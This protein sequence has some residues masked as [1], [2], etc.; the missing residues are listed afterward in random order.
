MRDSNLK[1]KSP[2]GEYVVPLANNI[3]RPVDE[4]LAE[5]ECGAAPVHLDY[6]D[7]I[8]WRCDSICKKSVADVVDVVQEE[9][10]SER[11]EVD[12][13]HVEPRNR[14]RN[15]NICPTAYHCRSFQV[16]NDFLRFRHEALPTF[17]A[18][19]RRTEQAK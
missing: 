9:E 10:L 17:P 4:S 19:L 18:T 8:L 1:R 6:G 12:I 5:N 13:A 15:S 2:R 11:G 3:R 14:G 16:V 7:L